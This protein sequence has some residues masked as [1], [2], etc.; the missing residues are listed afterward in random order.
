[1]A[2]VYRAER[3]DGM[4]RQQAAVKIL[5]LGALGATGRERFQ[6]EAAILARLTHPNVTALIDSGVADDGTFW[7]AMP[8]VDGDRIARWC[9]AKAPHAPA[10]VRLYL[11]FCG[12][13]PYPPRH[14]R[15]HRDL[16]PSNLRVHAN[17]HGP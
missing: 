6:R 5:T 7:L 17:A 14:P 15:L 11:Q 1:M 3:V 10:T 8:L 16:N 4:A 13:G 2:V 12:A 9:Q